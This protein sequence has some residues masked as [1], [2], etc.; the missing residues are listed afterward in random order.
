MRQREVTVGGL[1]HPVGGDEVRVRDTGLA[2]LRLRPG[3]QGR[4]LASWLCS[5]SDVPVRLTPTRCPCPDRS[6]SYSAA[7][8]A[9]A[10]RWPVPAS[11]TGGPTGVG[12]S[13]SHCIHREPGDA[14]NEQVL[15]G[16]AGARTHVAVSR[17]R[18][19]DQ[20]RVALA[21]RLVAQAKAVHHAG[22][23]VLDH[24]V[25]VLAQP[26]SERPSVRMLEID[27]HAALVAVQRDERVA[28]ALDRERRRGSLAGRVAH[29]GPLD[30][31]DLAPQIGQQL[32]CQ[33]TGH[34]LGEVDDLDPLKRSHSHHH[35]A[36]NGEEQA[37]CRPPGSPRWRRL[38]GRVSRSHAGWRRSP[39]PGATGSIGMPRIRT[40]SVRTRRPWRQSGAEH[41]REETDGAKR[42]RAPRA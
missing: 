5:D 17:D 39:R 40:D 42:R 20:A 30:L 34:E 7:E 9:S 21:Q 11:I 28:L 25:R 22:P 18:A 15:P 35:P 29:S 13:T 16:C 31:D 32:R 10:A 38:G 24:D 8:I 12:G 1:V 26:L 19:I 23:E 4:R 6:R 41:P 36:L 2:A 14:L 27:R 37:T 33:R 3:V